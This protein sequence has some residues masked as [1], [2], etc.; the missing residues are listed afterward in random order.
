MVQQTSLKYG[1]IEKTLDMVE[2][3]KLG[4]NIVYVMTV[5]P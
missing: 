2:K 1:G 3:K 4:T 5:H